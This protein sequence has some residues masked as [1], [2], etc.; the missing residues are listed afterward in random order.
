MS[1]EHAFEAILPHG[2]HALLDRDVLQGASGHFLHDGIAKHL[3]GGEQFGDGGAALEAGAS[4]LGA[5]GAANGSPD[6]SR[7]SDG[8]VI[9]RPD[10]GVRWST[11]RP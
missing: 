1:F 11:G 2:L 7:S 4:A 9:T 10:V 8:S 3:V 6:G 5:A